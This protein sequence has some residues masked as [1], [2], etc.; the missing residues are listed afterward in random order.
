MFDS[1]PA[2]GTGCCSG[3]SWQEYFSPLSPDWSCAGPAPQ[4]TQ[5]GRG[6]IFLNIYI[7]LPT[8][9]HLTVGQS[10]APRCGTHWTVMGSELT[11][12]RG[13]GRPCW[14]GGR[15]ALGEAWGPPA[16]GWQCWRCPTSG[17]PDTGRSRDTRENGRNASNLAHITWAWLNNCTLTSV[18][19]SLGRKMSYREER[20]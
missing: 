2:A 7:K 19:D 18:S 17:P 14:A 11:W 15:R 6:C 3:L 1:L 10:P 12:G 5:K 20:T 4:Q 16:G 9:C 8:E 13:P